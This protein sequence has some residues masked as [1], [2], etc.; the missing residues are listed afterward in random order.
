[1]QCEVRFCTAF[2]SRELT[3]RLLLLLPGALFFTANWTFLSERNNYSL[4][5]R[6][7]VVNA[8]M[9]HNVTLPVKGGLWHLSLGSV[10]VPLSLSRNGGHLSTEFVDDLQNDKKKAPVSTL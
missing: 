7:L 5:R 3:G 6:E 2:M 9:T 8:D 4:R 1:M 10:Q